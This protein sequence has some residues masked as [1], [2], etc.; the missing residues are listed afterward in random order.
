VTEDFDGRIVDHARLLG[1][2]RPGAAAGAL[3]RPAP[4]EYWPT[5]QVTSG[6]CNRHTFD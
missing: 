5:C 3:E 2:A 1:L 6:H 4:E